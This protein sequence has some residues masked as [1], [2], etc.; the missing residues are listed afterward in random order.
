MVYVRY[1]PVTTYISKWTCKGG[2]ACLYENCENEMSSLVLETFD[3][4]ILQKLTRAFVSCKSN[5]LLLKNNMI[6]KTEADL[7]YFILFWVISL[8]CCVL[9]Y[10]FIKILFIYLSIHYFG[11]ECC[12]CA[13]RCLNAVLGAVA[14]RCKWCN[15]MR[16]LL[17]SSH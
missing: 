12:A 1:I 6:C 9:V 3:N 11:R 5:T 17:P 14:K 10:L 8:D 13:A 15:N 7:P 4:V 16:R 2:D